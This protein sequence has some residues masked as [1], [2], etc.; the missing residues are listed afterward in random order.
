MLSA[1]E[2]REKAFEAKFVHDCELEFK[3]RAR[4]IS[5]LGHWAADIMGF[6]EREANEYCLALV[7]EQ[8]SSSDAQVAAHIVDDFKYH[9]I[10]K[11][12][13]EDVMEELSRLTPLAKQ[14]VWA[15]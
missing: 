5:L 3:V 7:K 12:H 15:H 11:F 1:M 8:V 13:Q 10:L 14:Q 2:Y 6:T 4:S 9:G